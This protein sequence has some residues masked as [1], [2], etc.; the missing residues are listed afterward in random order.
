M[1]TGGR[2]V[3]PVLGTYAY[4]LGTRSGEIAQAAA[5]SLSLVPLLLLALLVLFRWFDPPREEPA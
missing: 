5:W 4:W 2:I 3:F 1:L